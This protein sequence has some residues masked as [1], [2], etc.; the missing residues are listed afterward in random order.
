MGK[1]LV[2]QTTFRFP[3]E[4]MVKKIDKLAAEN[5]R[6]RRQEVEFIIYR[7]IKDYEETYGEI[8]IDDAAID[9]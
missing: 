5:C 9:N 1:N 6:N 2:K 3:D 7:Y 4:K 8:K